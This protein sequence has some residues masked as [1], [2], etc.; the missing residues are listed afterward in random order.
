MDSQMKKSP[1]SNNKETSSLVKELETIHQLIGD[2]EYTDALRRIEECENKYANEP[3][4][5][6]N[7]VGFLIDAGL[8]LGNKEI[9]QKAI[10]EGEILL[11][12]KR[13]VKQ[14]ATVLYNLSNGYAH[15][16][17]LAESSSGLAAIPKSTN[18]QKSKQ[19][20]REMLSRSD[21][22]QLQRTKTLVNYA[23]ELDHLGRGIEAIYAY[24]EALFIDPNFSMAIA[25]KAKALRTFAE[26]SGKYRG[27]IYAY[28]YQEIKSVIDNEDI[29]QVGGIAA[30]RG[31]EKE[32]EFIESR[33]KDKSVLMEKLKHHS[34]NA[35]DLSDFEKFYIDF[36][37][38][39]KLFLNFHIHHSECEAAID[40]PIFIRMITKIEDDLTFYNFAKYINQIKEDYAVARLSL[41]QSQY[42]QTDFDNISQRTDF[43]NALDH[44]QFNLYVG[45]LKSAFR[46]A[47]NILDKIAVFINDYYNLGLR[48]DRIYFT[49][50]W[51][52]EG[53]I[54]EEIL[55]SQNMSLYALYDIYLDFKAG[56]Y[57]RIK[58]IRN[59]LT[60]RRLVV[61]DSIITDWDKK[62]DKHNIGYDTM[63]D[64]T[65]ELMR[66]TKS[67]IIYLINFVNIE[68]NKKRGEGFIPQMDADT[69]QLF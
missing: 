16:F 13:F 21:I 24:D 69:S 2:G 43:V 22:D 42:R 51:Q 36:C 25:N 49:S 59:A 37:I 40:D 33:F 60:H 48:E 45:L 1:L 7:K 53:K 9:V 58:D 17:R 57:K 10:S 12:D 35:N 23:N 68:E 26:V 65:N 32:L 29:L 41:V 19:Y 47:F 3:A 55:K 30:K 15:L 34:Y 64:Q 66:L 54:R 8:H 38:R 62:N 44:S 18:L 14:Q 20:L 67:T 52:K 11:V 56:E 46:E 28:A 4:W 5:I 63:L 50:V 27:A 31:F 6:F 39:K 61:F